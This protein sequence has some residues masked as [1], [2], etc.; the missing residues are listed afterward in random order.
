MDVAT[1][2]TMQDEFPTFIP[3][4]TNLRAQIEP[5][6]IVRLKFNVPKDW[7]WCKANKKLA[8]MAG[9][10]KPKDYKNV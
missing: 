6:K 9:W 4:S 7:V 10:E 8:T 1:I 3:Y 2:M 5:G